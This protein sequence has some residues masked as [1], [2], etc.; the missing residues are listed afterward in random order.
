MQALFLSL[1]GA[2]LGQG[3]VLDLLLKGHCWCLIFSKKEPEGA[4]GR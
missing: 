4:G 1:P 3:L 2:E